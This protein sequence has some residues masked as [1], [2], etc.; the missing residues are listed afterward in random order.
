M[1]PS[2]VPDQYYAVTAR[3]A[4]RGHQRTAMRMV[5]GCIIMLTLPPMLALTNPASTR[6]PVGRPALAVIALTCAG[7]AALWLRHRWPTRE[8]SIAVVIAG[9]VALA[10]GCTLASD[11]LAG[12]LI[13]TAFPFVVGYAVLFHG[14]RLQMFTGGIAALTVL[15]LGFRIAQADVATAVA[16]TIPVV[17]VNVV[18]VYACRTI[19]EIAAD[20]D[21][22]DVEPLT[23]LLTRQSFDEAAGTL[24][25]A[26]SRGDD[27]YLV[28]VVATIDSFPALVSVRGDRGADSARVAVGQALRETVRHDAVVG[29]VGE[30]DFLVADS[31]TAPDPTPLAERIRG[32]VAAL[33]G[34][35]TASIGDVSTPLGPLA[36]CPPHEVLTEGIAL[37]TAAMHRARRRG[38]NTVEYVVAT[39]LGSSESDH[40]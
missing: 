31:F 28:L 9:S 4:A 24:L 2:N 15:W 17:M 22:T 10:T 13:S 6:V 32:A 5:A 37:A 25:G 23:G 27:R 1:K 35:L 36:G 16:V 30:A 11:P 21:R 40:E 18:T 29:H 34:G 20:R 12:L 33:P 8:Q 14:S 19:D 7:M 26:R 38:G 3:L 39:D